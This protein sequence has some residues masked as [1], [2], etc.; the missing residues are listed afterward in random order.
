[1]KKENAIGKKQSRCNVYIST[2]RFEVGMENFYGTSQREN[3][4]LLFEKAFDCQMKGDLHRALTLYRESVELYPY[5]EAYTFM[6]WTMGCLG[7]LTEAIDLCRRAIRVDPDFGNPYNDI[8]VYLME[9]G[10]YDEAEPWLERALRAPRY[11]CLH[12]P[13]FNLG[14]IHESRQDFH[15]AKQCYA[16]A[17]RE[18]PNYCLAR[19]ALFSLISRMN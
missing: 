3:A 18:N 19:K 15:L 11:D 5:A 2:Q 14:R 6:G 17:L 10:H 12:Y 13:W 7:R 8:G 4:L 1:M 16:R 9:Q